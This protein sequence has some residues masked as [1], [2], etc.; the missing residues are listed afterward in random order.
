MTAV[1]EAIQRLVDIALGV[2]PVEMVIQIVATLILVVVV[3]L[4]FWDKVTG[5]LDQRR[6]FI[7]KEL[8]D[9]ASKS[10][11]ANA[12]K[13]DAEEALDSA[14]EEAKSI[15][16]EAKTQGEEKKRSIVNEAKK[17]ADLVKKNA[18]RDIDQEIE[19]ARNELREEIV[20]IASLLSQKAIKKQ[21][22]KRV[23]DK[24]IDDAID[25]VRKQ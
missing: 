3:K 22:S 14:R 4:F 2:D 10:E 13:T 21:I 5:F 25:E 11:E 12:L 1:A 18:R 19:V 15:V 6:H 16:D 9:A 20:E 7:N 23:Y 17:E 8:E 24:L